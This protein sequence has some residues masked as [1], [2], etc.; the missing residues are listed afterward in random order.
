MVVSPTVIASD[1]TTK[2]QPPDID[3]EGRLELPEL[4]PAGEAEAARHLIEIARHRAQ[5]LVERERHV[6]GLAGEDGEDRRA[7]SA[8]HV[9]G[10]ETEEER[11]RKR[12]EAENRHRLQDVE[13]R[14]QHDL[15][16]PALGRQR[17]IGEG[18]QERTGQRGEHAQR[19]A[20]RIIGQRP[21][22]E[23]DRRRVG[24]RQGRRDAVIG[25]RDRRQ[26]RHDRR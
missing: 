6:P 7:F 1:A 26:R 10:K 8:K 16:A 4:L 2:N 14:D 23:A 13:N 11:H 12:Q 25:P 20:Q 21:V 24:S 3:G 9:A 5:R 15:G 17:R 18:E 19:R 22:V